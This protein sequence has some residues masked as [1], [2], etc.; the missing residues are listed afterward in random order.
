MPLH[1]TARGEGEPVILLHSGGMSARQWRKLGDALAPTHRVLT[2]DFLGSGENP[3]WPTGEPFHFQQDL[4]AAGELL[5]GVEGPVH[6]VGHSYG[7]LI[8]LALARTAPA[9]IRSLAVYD[10]VAFGVLYDT[11]DPEGLANLVLA[12]A[13]PLFSDDAQGGS[14]AW[15]E[16]FVDYWNGPGSWR[17][18]A[19]SAQEAFLR[20]G[21]KVYLE[22]S[23]LMKDRTPLSAYAAITA[24]SLLLFGERSPAAARRL[25]TL[26]GT[27]IP[28]ATV[29][30][31]ANAGHMGP[32]T[33][34]GAVNAELTRHIL[35]ATAGRSA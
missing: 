10:P 7:G 27:A 8:A 32:I 30:A 16:V 24:P 34:A 20:V 31:V 15:F 18:M 3:P 6:L 23:T 12:S 29:Q 9:K 21:R 33:H 5:S 35:A 2:P 25:V 17:A 14:D 19:P 22:V 1:V 4:E 28:N 11:R 26:L 13:H